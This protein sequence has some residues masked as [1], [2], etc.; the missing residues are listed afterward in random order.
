MDACYQSAK[1]KKW[2]PVK[3]D[4]WR[5]QTGLKDKIETVDYD[6]EHFLIKGEILPDGREKVIIKHKE[7][8]VISEKM[9]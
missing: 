7:T 4:D 9:V 2:E 6:D 5:G 1:S 3:L 8:G